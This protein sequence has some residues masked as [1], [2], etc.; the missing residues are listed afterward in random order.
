MHM[1]PIRSAEDHR[2]ALARIEAIW[3][4]APGSPEGVELDLLIDLVEHFEEKN[5]PMPEVDPIELLRAYMENAKRTQADLGRLLGSAPRASEILN[6][7]RPLTVDMIYKISSSWH[8]SAD[9]L[10]QPYHLASTD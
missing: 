9:R 4:A 3:G 10:V 2:N 8:I 1:K 6:R 7:K 5:F